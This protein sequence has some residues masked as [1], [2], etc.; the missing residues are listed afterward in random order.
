ML[1]IGLQINK[2]YPKI[3]YYR[4]FAKTREMIK[5]IKFKLI[6]ANLS[7]L[8][9]HLDL[10]CIFFWCYLML[11]LCM[12][13]KISRLMTNPTKW[14]VRPAKTKISL[15]ICPVWSESSLSAWRKL[16][17]LAAHWAHSEDWLEWADAQADLS[18]LGA[19]SFC[20]FCHVAAQILKLFN[21]I[22]KIVVT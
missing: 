2:K 12:L 9:K 1:K 7:T 15:G 18:S 17:S 4:D 20:W 5:K 13:D 10:L 6:L 22:G 11:V 16:G 19:Q 21:F 8:F 3:F 14:H